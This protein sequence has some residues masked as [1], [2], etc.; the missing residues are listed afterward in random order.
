[1]KAIVYSTHYFEKESLAKANKKKHDITL[2]SNA[3]NS[4]TAKFAEGKD[5]VIVFTN[6]DVSSSVIQKLKEFG[7][8]YIS[9]RSLETSH[10]DKVAAA[11]AGVK[12]ANIPSYTAENTEES[13]NNISIQ[14]IKHLDNWQAKKC[15]KE[16]CAN[17]KS[18]R[19]NKPE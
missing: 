11:K 3:L 8:R 13:L 19:K 9:T 1:M 17:G 16:A 2:I 15:M 5:A 18:C 7:I 4:E 14:I 6:D 12:V 10:I